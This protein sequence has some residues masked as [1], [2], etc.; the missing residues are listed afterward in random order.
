VNVQEPWLE[1]VVFLLF[2]EGRIYV[3]IDE[4]K[5]KSQTKT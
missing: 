3:A 5:Q 4:A 2:L 1:R